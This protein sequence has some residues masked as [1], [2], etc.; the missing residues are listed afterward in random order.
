MESISPAPAFTIFCRSPLQSLDHVL[1]S[2]LAVT[3]WLLSCVSPS[4]HSHKVLHTFLRKRCMP[5]FGDRT[6]GMEYDKALSFSSFTRLAF[7]SSTSILVMYL[8]GTTTKPTNLLSIST[9]TFP[10]TPSIS[11][12]MAA[13][14]TTLG[15]GCRYS[16]VNERMMLRSFCAMVRRNII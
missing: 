12:C 9:L 7:H 6:A 3:F 2:L 13:F 15:G 16:C 1:P 11:I 14:S 10:F 8:P 4:R 5:A